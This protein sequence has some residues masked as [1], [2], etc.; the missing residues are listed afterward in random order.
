MRADAL[1]ILAA[2]GE[3][4]EFFADLR[5]DPEPAIAQEA[6]IAL[7]ERQDRA[8]IERELSR[9]LN[10][11]SALKAG[12]VE[13][14]YDSSLNWIGK[15]RQEFAWD[16]LKRLRER[17]LCL[18]LDR[19]T[20]IMTGCLAQ[21]DSPAAASLI[22]QQVNAAPAA[23]RHHLQASAVEMEQAAR[24]EK[25]QQTPFDT[26]LRKLRGSTS[27]DKLLVVCE[28]STDVPV[29]RALLA[30][31]PDA[32]EVIF[33]SVGGWSGLVNKDPNIFLL[34]AK[35]AIVVMDGDNGRKL[36]AQ[37]LPLTDQARQQTARLKA[38]GVELRVLERYGIENYFPLQAI[39]TVLQRDLSSFFPLPHNVPI[40]DHLSEIVGVERQTFYP[41]SRNRHVASLLPRSDPV[42]LG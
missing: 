1:Q 34:G 33:D 15:I 35:E 9:L 4:N 10:D 16:K 42:A 21:I 18:G 24:I 2:Q 27:A 25:A 13:I 38:N 14:G 26:V 30:Q 37:A 3:K 23:W 20:M 39:E 22:R 31:L 28:G 11:D 6:F 29:F 7:V 12:E 41:K 32:P 36:D 19:V 17:A 8:T 40:A 5:Q